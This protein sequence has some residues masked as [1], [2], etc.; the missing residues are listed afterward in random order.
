MPHLIGYKPQALN[1]ILQREKETKS[2]RDQER[3]GEAGVRENQDRPDISQR[4]PRWIRYIRENQGGPD[5]S[6]DQ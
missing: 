3:L 1:A 4:E 5:V 2:K 6:R